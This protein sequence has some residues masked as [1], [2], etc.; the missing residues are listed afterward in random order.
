MSAVQF[1]GN[2]PVVVSPVSLK[3]RFRPKALVEIPER[4]LE[5]S[6]PRTDPKQWGIFGAVWTLLSIKYVSEGG[7]QEATYY[8]ITGPNGLLNAERGVL[9]LSYPQDLSMYLSPMYHVFRELSRAQGMK[10]VSVSSDQPLS[11]DAL[12]FQAEEQTI[13]Y[14][15]N[16]HSLEQTTHITGLPSDRMSGHLISESDWHAIISDPTYTWGNLEYAAGKGGRLTIH[17]PP[18]SVAK[19]VTS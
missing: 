13:L 6:Y 14:V 7:A 2:C 19:I 11:V 10:L 4:F 18:Y 8:E 16:L 3:M 12:A 17:L 1:A 15:T 5:E 9:P